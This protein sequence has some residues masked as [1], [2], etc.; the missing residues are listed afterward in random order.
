MH[1]AYFERMLTAT[2][3]YLDLLK[4]FDG[5]ITPDCSLLVGQ[6]ACLQQTNTY[7]SRAVGY[8]LQKQG[9]P[10]IPNVRWSDDSSF[11]YCF[12]GIPRNT[13]VAVST[14]GC[15]RSREQKCRFKLGLEEMIRRLEP[16]DIVVHGYMPSEVF[17]DYEG[18]VHFHRYSSWFEETHPQKRGIA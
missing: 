14:H 6:A 18:D 12:L 8:F 5:V 10:V 1:D 13:I 16:T 17:S 3:Q 2:T 4:Q 9:I 11:D 7:F 15:I